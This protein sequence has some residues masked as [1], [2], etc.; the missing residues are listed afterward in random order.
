M[1]SGIHRVELERRGQ[2][3]KVC[4]C[5]FFTVAQSSNSQKTVFLQRIFPEVEEDVSRE[6]AIAMRRLRRGWSKDSTGIESVKV[7]R[8]EEKL[9]SD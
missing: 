6:R 8:E 7:E 2:R 4:V 1:R 5:C 9:I 3:N